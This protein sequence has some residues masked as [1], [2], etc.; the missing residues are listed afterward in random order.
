MYKYKTLM[1][2]LPEFSWIIRTPITFHRCKSFIKDKDV[3]MLMLKPLKI[4]SKFQAIRVLI[5]IHNMKLISD[6]TPHSA[7]VFPL[8]VYKEVLVYIYL[9]ETNKLN[10]INKL[11][12]ELK[13]KFLAYYFICL[14]A[15]WGKTFIFPTRRK[16]GASQP[17]F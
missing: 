10:W 15:I 5:L 2:F 17:L 13:S 1:A 4:L 6:R 8:H 14:E 11:I 3:Y 16:I 9:L 12:N 7:H